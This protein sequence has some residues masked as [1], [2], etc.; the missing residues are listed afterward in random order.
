MYK[1]Q[2]GIAIPEE[3]WCGGTCLVDITLGT[4]I[5]TILTTNPRIPM[6]N[7]TNLQEHISIIF[8][9]QFVTPTEREETH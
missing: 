1:N 6:M 2:S 8:F 9:F 5:P 7:I 4:I 3:I